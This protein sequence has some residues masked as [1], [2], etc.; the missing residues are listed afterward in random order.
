[1]TRLWF[2]I[3][4]ALPRAPST[5][6]VGFFVQVGDADGDFGFHALHGLVLE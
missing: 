1:M 2:R 4:T 5:M 3:A 6:A